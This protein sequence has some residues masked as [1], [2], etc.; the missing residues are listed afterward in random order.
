M[1]NYLV[2]KTIL[3]LKQ[4]L[5]CMYRLREKSLG[6]LRKVFASTD[7]LVEVGVNQYYFVTIFFPD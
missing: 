5:S 3:I 6:K 2:H 1:G 7:I 4:F